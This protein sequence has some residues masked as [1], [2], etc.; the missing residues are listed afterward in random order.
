MGC[1]SHSFRN[2]YPVMPFV[3]VKLAA[4]CDLDGARAEAFAAEFGAERAYTDHR[5]MLNSH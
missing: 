3:P 2:L 1:G 4:V 5:R